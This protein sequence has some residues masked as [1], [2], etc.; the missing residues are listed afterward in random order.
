MKKLIIG[1][2]VVIVIVLGVFFD[3]SRLE[4]LII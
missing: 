4:S 3:M 1:I 2:S